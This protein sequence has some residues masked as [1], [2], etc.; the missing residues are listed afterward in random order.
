MSNWGLFQLLHAPIWLFVGALYSHET[1]VNIKT[2]AIKDYAAVRWCT[3]FLASGFNKTL[4]EL[5]PIRRLG[6]PLVHPLLI[7][8]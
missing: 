7:H 1:Y 6:W 4:R 2:A 5:L 3:I 8:W